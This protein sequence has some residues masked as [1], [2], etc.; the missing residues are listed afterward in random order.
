MRFVHMLLQIKTQT[1][2]TNEV[3]TYAGSGARATTDGKDE[4]HTQRLLA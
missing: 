2:T 1:L 4:I 3:I